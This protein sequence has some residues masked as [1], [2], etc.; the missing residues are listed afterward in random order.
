VAQEERYRTST[1]DRLIVLFDRALRTLAAEPTGTGRD[2]P[3]HGHQDEALEE[4]ERRRAGALIRVDHAGEVAAQ[5]L[6]HGQAVAARSARVRTAMERSAHEESDHLLWCRE[7]LGELGARRSYLDPLWYGGSFAI[8]ALAGLA[9]DRW[10][11]GFVA[12]T[13]RQVVRH[14]DRHL[15]ALPGGDRRSR[16]ILLQMREDEGRHASVALHEGAAELPAPARWTMAAVSRLMTAGAY[17]L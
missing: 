17:W 16:A 11:L 15:R 8:G 4:R 5:A 14:I 12:E 3:A 10:S 2:N 6:Y 7:R 9:G 13:E 1:L